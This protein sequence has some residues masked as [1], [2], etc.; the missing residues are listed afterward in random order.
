[1][2]FYFILKAESPKM[3]ISQVALTC[4]E[5]RNINRFYLTGVKKLKQ[6]ISVNLVSC[7]SGDN[8]GVTLVTSTV[9]RDNTGPGQTPGA[10]VTRNIS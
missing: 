1:M 7:D 8:G 10:I 5:V 3:E 9:A 6:L 2:L 4:K